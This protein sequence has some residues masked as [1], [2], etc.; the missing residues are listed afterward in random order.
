[1]YKIEGYHKTDGNNALHY[2]T[3]FTINDESKI[4]EEVSALY[5]E[6]KDI[7]YIKVSRVTPLREY[8]YTNLKTAVPPSTLIIIKYSENLIAKEFVI[9]EDNIFN[10]DQLRKRIKD[11]IF[12]NDLEDKSCDISVYALMH[13]FQHSLKPELKE[14]NVLP[15]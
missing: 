7:N 2:V 14:I 9:K 13:E 15:F 11:I 8:D 1:M 4:E 6:H 12:E 3:S 5:L 10:D